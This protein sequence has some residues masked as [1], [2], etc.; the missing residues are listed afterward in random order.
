MKKH[1]QSKSRSATRREA[2]DQ[3]LTVEE[4]TPVE[5]LALHEEADPRNAGICPGAR[6]SRTDRR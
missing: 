1:S 3:K 5:E 6:Q 4:P 2:V